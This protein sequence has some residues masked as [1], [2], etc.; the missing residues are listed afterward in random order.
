MRGEEP[1]PSV[2][3]PY[4]DRAVVVAGGAPTPGPGPSAA[5][6]DSWGEDSWT[7]DEDG[8]DAWELTGRR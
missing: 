8:E 5:P 7:E 2:D 3:D 4:D 1:P 6:A